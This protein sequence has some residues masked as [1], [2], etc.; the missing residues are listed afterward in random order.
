MLAEFRILATGYLLQIP[1]LL[2]ELEKLE[3]M[4]NPGGSSRIGERRAG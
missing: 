2:V 4:L 1:G 3:A